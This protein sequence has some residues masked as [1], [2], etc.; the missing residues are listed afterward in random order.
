M[1]KYPLLED[2]IS[3]FIIVLKDKYHFEIVSEMSILFN[4]IWTPESKEI[5]ILLFQNRYCIEEN[6]QASESGPCRFGS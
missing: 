5:K 1:Y 3:L 2:F 4:T 6:I